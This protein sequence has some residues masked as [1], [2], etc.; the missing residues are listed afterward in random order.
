MSEA[1]TRPIRILV[2][3]HSAVLFTGMAEVAR[4]I[5]GSLISTFPGKYSIHQV[6]LIHVSA[7]V[8]LPWPITPTEARQLPDGKVVLVA[9]DLHGEL[10]VKKVLNEFE[11]DIVFAH[12]DPQKVGFLLEL[13]KASR[14]KLVLYINFDGIPVP[15]EYA[16]LARA[17][18]LITLSR[19]SRSAYLDMAGNQNHPDIGV[20]YPPADITRFFPASTQERAELRAN[21]F[22]E[23][24]P[25]DAFVLGW[26]GRNQWRKQVWIIYAAI[27]LLRS[28]RYLTC[29]MCGNVLLEAH[30][31]RHRSPC[32]P[33]TFCPA[34]P[35]KQI[36]LWVHIPTGKEPGTWPLHDLEA[37]YGAQPGRDVYYTEGCSA[38]RHLPPADMPSLYRIW[39]ALLLPSGSEGFGL[40][41]WE[42]MSC[43]LPV[44]FSDYSSHA[45]FIRDADSGIAVSGILQPEAEQCILR[46]VPRVEDVVKAVRSLYY[47]KSLA[48]RLGS[49]GRH[50][51]EGFGLE[52]MARRWDDIF[53]GLMEST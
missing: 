36:F 50:F 24:L 23:W 1:A 15:C 20:M 16:A 31:R 29:T 39:D 5:F 47:D 51:V 44:V 52:I 22:P 14:W 13:R 38:R 37:L 18:R 48:N 41:A 7:V 10:T 42:A 46:L 3:T 35:L 21:N 33:C 40:P 34:E 30:Q 45:E 25:T 28:G 12:N 26:I 8:E 4:L 43:G 17:D 9:E 6:G 27:G 32:Q 19:F 11:P 49:N 53:G 2:V